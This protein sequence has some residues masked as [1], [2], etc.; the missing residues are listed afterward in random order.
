MGDLSEKYRDMEG[1]DYIT[2]KG[3]QIKIVFK[4]DYCKKLKAPSMQT[5]SVMR[6]E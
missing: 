2:T 4:K 5:L 1:I 3:K 6:G